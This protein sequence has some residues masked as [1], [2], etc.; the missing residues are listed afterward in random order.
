MIRSRLSFI[1]L[2]VRNQPSFVMSVGSH[3]TYETRGDNGVFQDHSFQP[4]EDDFKANSNTA[5]VDG[6]L[7][8]VA[9]SRDGGPRVQVYQLD[10]NQ[11]AVKTLDFFAFE[12]EFRG[13]VNVEFVYNTASHGYNLVVAAS[14]QGGP[15][16]QRYD[17]Q[18][19]KLSD[20][21]VF[22]ESERNGVQLAAYLDTLFVGDG[23]S[24]RDLESGE[25][26]WSK[27]YTTFAYGSVLGQKPQVYVTDGTTLST[28]SKHN[29]PIFASFQK[30]SFGG[31]VQANQYQ[32]IASHEDGSFVELDDQFGIPLSYDT[33]K[34]DYNDI[35]TLVGNTQPSINASEP[36]AGLDHLETLGYR[37]GI[38]SGLSIGSPVGTGTY[39]ATVSY[40]GTPVGLTNRHVVEPKTFNGPLGSP[41]FSPGPA[42]SASRNLVGVTLKK[43]DIEGDDVDSALFS[44]ETIAPEQTMFR[45]IYIDPYKSQEVTET[46]PLTYDSAITLENGDVTYKT[47]R[48]TGL[49][50]GVVLYDDFSVDV[51][52]PDDVVRTLEHQIVVL[53]NLFAQPGDSGSPVIKVVNDKYYLVAQL[54]AGSTQYGIVTPINNVFTKMG[55]TLWQP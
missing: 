19:N 22:N 47:G 14:G 33:Y 20:E 44:I 2:E 25:T 26:V 48:T 24:I 17:L 10:A 6:E 45:I 54:F 52:Y 42:D 32:I 50:R 30:L 28:V 8:A 18:G 13:G 23:Q 11:V 37:Q 1:E 15:R 9:P 36:F 5:F 49:T 41:I 12:P 21:F 27:P 3:V 34:R 43:S 31:Y 35:R 51:G 7:I 53:G 46:L 4:F 38:Y 40:N 29:T 55:V 39:T 16:L